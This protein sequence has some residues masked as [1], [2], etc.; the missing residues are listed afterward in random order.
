MDRCAT[1][2]VAI[3]AWTVYVT[4]TA[5]VEVVD[6]NFSAEGNYHCNVPAK[7]SDLLCQSLLYCRW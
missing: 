1:S 3:Y 6:I 4:T 7:V 5:L 2:L